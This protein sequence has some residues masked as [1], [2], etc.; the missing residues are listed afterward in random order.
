M[1]SMGY[2]RRPN[3]CKDGVENVDAAYKHAQITHERV[4][5]ACEG[6]R[7]DV[8]DGRTDTLAF[9]EL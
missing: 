2:V 5:E 1:R 9:W 7:F 3:L 4:H 6:C 8:L